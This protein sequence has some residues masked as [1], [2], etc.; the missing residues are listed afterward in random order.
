MKLGY[1]ILRDIPK[2]ALTVDFVRIPIEGGFRGFRFVPPGPHYITVDTSETERAGFWCFMPEGEVLIK[3][4]DQE[5]NCFSDDTPESAEHYT[6]LAR[7]RAMDSALLDF[8]SQETD[9]FWSLTFYIRQYGSLPPV[10][11][12]DEKMSVAQMITDIYNKKTKEALADFQFTFL[13]MFTGSNIN[14]ADRDLIATKKWTDMII[15]LYNAEAKDISRYATFM[16]QWTS[17]LI[18]QLNHL[19]TRMFAGPR[20]SSAF[21]DIVVY[22]ARGLVDRMLQSKRSEVPEQGKYFGEYLK[23]REAGKD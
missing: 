22:G 20:G 8:P 2:K 13:K 3:V 18:A 21:Y 9:A 14:L 12:I 19:P 1:I 5:Q 4:F 6:Q 15:V 16:V 10:K 23:E 7:S 11:S 17:V